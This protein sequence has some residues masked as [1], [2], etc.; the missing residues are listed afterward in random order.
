MVCKAALLALISCIGS[1]LA[2]ASGNYHVVLNDTSALMSVRACFNQHQVSLRT[3]RENSY[4]F[5]QAGSLKNLTLD[6]KQHQ[7]SIVTPNTCSEYSVDLNR[8]V[9]SRQAR[10]LDRTWVVNNQAWLW[11]PA[12]NSEFN[13][14]FSYQNSPDMSVSVPWKMTSMGYR[15]GNTPIGWT[16][17]MAFGQL[18]NLPIEVGDIRLRAS[19]INIQEPEKVSDISDWLHESMFSISQ[20]YGRFPVHHAQ[21]LVIPIGEQKEAIPWAEVQRAG[22]P[23]VHLFIDQNR[24][25]AEFKQDW[26]TAHEFSHLLLPRIEYRDRWLSEGLA[27]YYQNIAK[28][29]AGLLTKTQ[30]WNKLIAGFAKG[31]KTMKTHLR[32]SRA[33]KHIYWGGAAIFLL[34][35][36]QLRQLEQPSSLDEVLDKLQKCCIPSDTLWSAKQLTNTLDQLSHSRIFSGLLSHQARLNRFPLSEKQQTEL[37][38]ATNRLLRE[39]MH[40]KS[41]LATTND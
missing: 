10:K 33:T 37:D 20:I 11:R 24:P 38:P 29:R 19:L 4:H 9:A 35:D 8:A 39:I 1:S 34:A 14:T 30:A 36:I 28:V 40:T 32:D 17:R 3:G 22:L 5:L 23:A 21:I 6:E 41:P 18:T 25:I 15:V 26:T 12:D 16:S 7:L 27:S 2:F 31:R 13:L